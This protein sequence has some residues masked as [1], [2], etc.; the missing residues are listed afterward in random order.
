MRKRLWQLQQI[1]PPLW[2]I[3]FCFSL[4]SSQ[5]FLLIPSNLPQIWRYCRCTCGF[6]DFGRK[7]A[8]DP[9]HPIDFDGFVLRAGRNFSPR[10]KAWLVKTSCVETRIHAIT[11]SGARLLLWA[12]RRHLLNVVWVCVQYACRSFRHI[13]SHALATEKRRAPRISPAARDV[14]AAAVH[15][16]SYRRLRNVGV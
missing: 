14:G 2:L 9:R 16:L 6:Q 1:R 3:L 8:S 11:V 13:R 4:S 7:R 12:Q 15:P 10:F 5:N